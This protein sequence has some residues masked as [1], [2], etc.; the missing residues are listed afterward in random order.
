MKYKLVVC[1]GTF[2]HFHKGHREFL[3]YGLSISDKLL[4]GLTT[5][6]FVKA[7]DTI[8]SIYDYKTRKQELENFFIQEKA[9]NKVSIEPIG[10]I[11][12]P[13]IWEQLSIEAIVVSENTISAAK[14]INLIRK[15]Q[16]KYPLIIETVR[17][18]KSEHNE[19][20]SSSSIRSGEINREGRLNVNPYWLNHSLIITEELRKEF[21][22]PF[23]ILIKDKKDYGNLISPFLITVGDITTKVFNQIGLNQ[24]ISVIDFRVARHK[25]FFSLKDLGFSKVQKVIRVNNPQGYLTSDLFKAVSNIFGSPKSRCRIVL[26]IEGEEDLSVL[27]LTLRAPLNSIVFYGQP[28]EGVVRVDITEKSKEVAYGLTNQFKIVNTNFDNILKKILYL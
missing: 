6:E 2:D 18:V 12:I 3:Q 9:R 21:K 13:K 11:Y 19:Y 7:K 24:N 27:P 4:V 26:K 17:L 22:K 8:E 28:G 25:E 16:R 1:G 10:S 15:E 5:D 23:G 20:I 14:K